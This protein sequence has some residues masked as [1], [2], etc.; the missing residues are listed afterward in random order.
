MKDKL[1]Q[2]KSVTMIALVV[3]VIILLILTNMLI[4]NAQDSVY[5]QAL[6]NLYTDI[7]LL[8]DKVSVYYNQY[9]EI[10]AKI[11]YTTISQLESAN[12]LSQ[13]N[14]IKDEFYVIDLEAM[15]GI[16]LNY[17][18]DYEKIKADTENANNYTDVYIINKNSHNIFY[19]QGI[20]IQQNEETNEDFVSET[21]SEWNF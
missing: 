14:D 12:I 17:G 11:K 19:A 20:G 8:R 16:T 9:G 2:N 6:N 13:N 3:T 10:P 4:Y 1:K 18:K 21:D 5:I 15:Q 7:D